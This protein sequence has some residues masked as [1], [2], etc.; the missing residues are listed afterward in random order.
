MED[1]LLMSGLESGLLW[2]FYGIYMMLA[3]VWPIAVYVLRSLGFY[4]M[5]QNRGINKPWLAWIPVGDSWILGSL[6]DQYRYVA[7][8]EVKNRRKVLLWLNIIFFAVYFAFIAVFVYF[9]ISTTLGAMNGVVSDEM[10]Y[11][12]LGAAFGMLGIALVMLVVAVVMAVFQY[13]AL[14]DLYKSCDPN[15]ATLFLLLS[16]FVSVTMPFFVFFLRNKEGGMPP[17]REVIAEE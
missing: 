2:G 13:I 10:L 15:N 8:G 5:A 6:A 17:R 12:T 4:K 11:E 16:I 14:F 7:K 1:L 9:I 3:F